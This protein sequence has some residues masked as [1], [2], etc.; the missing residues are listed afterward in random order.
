M[1][2]EL[3]AVR[4]VNQYRNRDILAYIGLRYYLENQCARRDRWITDIATQLVITRTSPSYFR[5][6]HFKDFSDNNVEHRYIHIP[7]PNEA[8]AEAALINECSKYDAFQSLPSVYS[9]RFPD[10]NSKEGVY[11][12]YFSGLKKRHESLT[13]FCK[14]SSS[15]IIQY[16]DIKK[17]YPHITTELALQVWQ[18]TCKKSGIESKYRELGEKI[19]SDHGSMSSGA[20]N[21]KGLLTGPMISHLIANLVLHD[22]DEKM[23]AKMP[24][25]YWRY[26]DDVILAGDEKKVLNGRKLLECLLEEKGLHLHNGDK[27]FKVST[28]NW[29]QGENDF[30]STENGNLWWNLTNNIKRFLVVNPEQKVNLTQAFIENGININLP[31]YASAVTESNY[32]EKFKDWLVKYDVWA[33]KKSRS[34]S[35]AGLVNESLYVRELLHKKINSLLENN[36]SI[37]GYERKRLIPKLR[38]HAGQIA[39]LGTPD[40]LCSI[41]EGLSLYPELY[42][43]SKVMSTAESR[44]VSDLLSLGSNAVQSAAQILRLQNTSVKCSLEKFGDVESQGIAILQLNGIEIH[45]QKSMELISPLNSFASEEN[46]KKL[47]KSDDLFIKELACLHGVDESKRHLSLLNSAFDRDED[48][49]FDIINLAL[50]VS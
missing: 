34:L 44:D 12:R 6:I 49:A 41:S 21:G 37:D 23:S 26:V 7:S 4:A 11:Q 3:L 48:L 40:I 16:T 28:S 33:I 43:L 39:Y 8:L 38:Y 27:D 10:K 45:C 18:K 25:Q 1:R 36:P 2:P 29:L 30:K 5:S 31:D 42:V 15:T 17:F 9:Y 24:N 32:R 50:Y 46:M 22:I 14:N 47:M 13:D 20:N 19:L 35:I